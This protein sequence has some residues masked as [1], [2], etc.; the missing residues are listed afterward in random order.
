MVTAVHEVVPYLP[1]PAGSAVGRVLALATMA[2]TAWNTP[3]MPPQP[4]GPGA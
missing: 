1:A 3:P 2:L 4:D